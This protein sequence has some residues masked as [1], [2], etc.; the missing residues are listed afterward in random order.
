[1]ESLNGESIKGYPLELF[2][3][4]DIPDKYLCT[5]C[6]LVAQNIQLVNCCEK[7]F[8]L[9]CIKPRRDKN[10]P[11]PH[12]EDDDFEL[13]SLKKEKEKIVNLKVCCTEKAKG[14]EWTG[15]LKDL[16]DHLHKE[17]D[18]C[19]F[20][21]RKCPKCHQLINR[22]DMLHHQEKECPQ[23]EYQ[24][25]YCNYQGSYDNV[26]RAH[27]PDC[28]YCPV[29]CPNQC[30][31]TCERA[32]MDEHI[33]NI[34]PEQYLPCEYE[35]AGCE[36]QYR[37][38]DKDKHMNEYNSDHRLKVEVHKQVTKMMKKYEEKRE[39]ERASEQ[40]KME[41]EM[42]EL[43]DKIDQLEHQ[44][45]QIRREQCDQNHLYQPQHVGE[46]SSIRRK[47]HKNPPQTSVASHSGVHIQ[48]LPI[49]RPWIST[50]DNFTELKADKEKWESDIIQ[51]PLGYRLQLNVWPNGQKDGEGSHVSVWLGYLSGVYAN[52]LLFPVVM[53][54]KLELHDHF[55]KWEL[56]KTE[57]FT[58]TG[59]YKFQFNYLGTFND[60][61]LISHERLR[62]RQFIHNDS[63]TMCVTLLEERIC[64]ELEVEVDGSLENYYD[65]QLEGQ[66][67]KPYNPQQD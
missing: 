44:L 18:G 49:D 39:K 27:L 22:C 28:T 57:K 25:K 30:G 31:V 8:C 10:Q 41:R 60:N 50:I 6:G 65:S 11:C 4:G 58:L 9:S 64:D 17:E 20:C 7:R 63:I 42:R 59:A 61:K 37:R 45:E 46:D 53:T 16:Y 3:E 40:E 48:P 67:L 66:F 33:N 34:C 51:T 29:V 54:M 13:M 47:K 2:Q 1:M 26:M 24:C 21:T 14:C 5:L 36:T 12:C 43:R 56:L 19:Q 52:A 38:K 23:R 32:Q 55:G 15:K 62:R 35:Y